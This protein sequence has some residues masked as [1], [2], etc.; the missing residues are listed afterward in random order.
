MSDIEHDRLVSEFARL[1][2]KFQP[3]CEFVLPDGGLCCEKA[4]KERGVPWRCKE[5]REAAK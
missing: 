2:D 3:V 5:H 1:C 4:E